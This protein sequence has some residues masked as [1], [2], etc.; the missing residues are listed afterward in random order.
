[1]LYITK[2]ASDK[3]NLSKILHFLYSERWEGGMLFVSF[4]FISKISSK[5][6]GKRFQKHTSI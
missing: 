5:S 3:I 2:P 4:L 6:Y 1:M